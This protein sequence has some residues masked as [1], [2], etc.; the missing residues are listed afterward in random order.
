MSILFNNIPE[1]NIEEIFIFDKIIV[2]YKI[3]KINI[4]EQRLWQ[5]KL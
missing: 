5:R 1:I 4:K 3:K 2:A